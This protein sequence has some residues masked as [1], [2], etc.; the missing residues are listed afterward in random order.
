MDVLAGS[1][2]ESLLLGASNV[3]LEIFFNMFI[4]IGRS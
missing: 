1:L 3:L 4:D 2:K